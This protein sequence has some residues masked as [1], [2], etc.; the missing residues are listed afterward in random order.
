MVRGH[1]FFVKS[2]AHEFTQHWSQISSKYIYSD[3]FHDTPLYNQ[4]QKQLEMSRA[5]TKKLIYLKLKSQHLKCGYFLNVIS[6][7]IPVLTCRI[8]ST[9]HFICSPFSS[10]ISF[11]LLFLHCHL[12]VFSLF[13]S[14][15]LVLHSSQSANFKLKSNFYWKNSERVLKSLVCFP[16]SVEEELLILI[17]NTM[18]IFIANKLNAI[19]TITILSSQLSFSSHP[20]T[21]QCLLPSRKFRSCS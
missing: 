5:K 14:G 2:G 19:E 10:S 7:S 18:L 6:K 4:L 12:N 21:H 3:P 9:C 13:L 17:S 1:Y 8:T 16:L 20:I 15:F 11:S